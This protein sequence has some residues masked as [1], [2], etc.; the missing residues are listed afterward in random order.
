MEQQ[1][2]QHSLH[3]ICKSGGPVTPDAMSVIANGMTMLPV[4]LEKE[5]TCKS[6]PLHLHGDG[7]DFQWRD[8][9]LAFSW[10]CLHILRGSLLS[11]ML[12]AACPKLA[13][14]AETWAPLW[15]WIS[16]GM[17]FPSNS[18]VEL[19]TA[20]SQRDHH[21]WYEEEDS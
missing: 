18:K 9:L 5:F 14:T 6:I 20:A 2:V 8:C 4:L 19:Q 1:R 15:K 11:N 13:T 3:E 10:G 12:I 21:A 7:A 17:S 16:T